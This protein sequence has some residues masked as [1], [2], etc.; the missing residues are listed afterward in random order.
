LQSAEA[1]SGKPLLDLLRDIQHG[2]GT[3]VY[4]GVSH[5]SYL[6]D[7]GNEAIKPDH[8]YRLGRKHNCDEAQIR[9]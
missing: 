1:G 8:F 7:P 4:T 6:L 2:K 3:A 9:R 5:C